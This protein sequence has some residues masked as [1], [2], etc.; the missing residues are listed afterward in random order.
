MN[1]YSAKVRES[2]IEGLF[3]SLIRI[4]ELEYVKSHL[5]FAKGYDQID[6][7]EASMGFSDRIDGIL[8]DYKELGVSEK[9]KEI[10]VDFDK[11]LDHFGDTVPEFAR[12]D[13]S[14]R[15][16]LDKIKK[17][18]ND[19]LEAFGRPRRDRTGKKYFTRQMI[20]KVIGE[21]CGIMRFFPKL[22][23]QERQWVCREEDDDWI[24]YYDVVYKYEISIGFISKHYEDLGFTKEQRECVEKFRKDFDAFESER[25]REREFYE[26]E[27]WLGIVAGAEELLK[28]LGEK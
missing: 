10:L 12:S 18:A 8:Q 20:G 5:S 9:Q 1:K 27:G 2:I 15:P 21:F 23:K 13:C 19:V 22:L 24:D 26:V 16:E 6:I 11:N 7:D 3:E 17:E 4:A 25:D 28:V 14:D